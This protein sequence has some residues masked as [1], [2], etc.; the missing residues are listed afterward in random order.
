MKRDFIQNNPMILRALG[1][2]MDRKV[3]QLP[4]VEHTFSPAFEQRMDRLIRAQSRPYYRY[5]NTGMK[6]AVLALAAVFLLLTALMFSVSAL[7]EPVVRFIVKVYEKITNVHYQPENP[8]QLPATLEVYYEPAWLPKGY[9]LN[10]SMTIDVLILYSLTYTDEKE[11]DINFSQYTIIGT[12]L[13]LDTEGTKT[14]PITVN[15]NA[16]MFFS[17][18]GIQHILWN[19]GQ[20]G[21]QL[22]GPVTKADLL[23]MARSFRAVDRPPGTDSPGMAGAIQEDTGQFPSTLEVLFDPTWLPEGY[24]LDAKSGLDYAHDWIYVND[25][26]KE[27][28][29]TQHTIVSIDV[30]PDEEHPDPKPITVNGNAGYSFIGDDMPYLIWKDGQYGYTLYGPVPEADLLRMAQSLRAAK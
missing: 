29:L 13:G 17:N 8:E 1:E 22:F 12:T 25:S 28:R 21:F 30:T 10:D 18:K 20:Y 16:G 11:N 15:G 3:E 19:D 27:I 23:R 4:E 24:R 7:R 26:G 9:R 14:K 6:K 5:V 2:S